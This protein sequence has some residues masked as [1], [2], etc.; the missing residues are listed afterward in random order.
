MNSKIVFYLV[1]ALIIVIG[2]VFVYARG[3]GPRYIQQPIPFNHK[4][5]LTKVGVEDCAFCHE[6]VQEYAVAGIPSIKA[7]GWCHVEGLEISDELKSEYPNAEELMAEVRDYAEKGR[8]IQWVRMYKNPDYVVFS[9][10]QHIRQKVSCQEC[11]GKMG[12]D[13]KAVVNAKLI[14]M[15]RCVKCHK[16]RKVSTDCLTCHK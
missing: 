9:H 13:A 6:Y 5:H 4:W 15:K 3:F 7:C 1:I 10:R 11:H 12:Q 14:S 2:G 16:K 8:E